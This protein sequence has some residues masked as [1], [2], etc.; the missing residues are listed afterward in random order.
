MARVESGDPEGAKADFWALLKAT[1][2]D[3]KEAV[4]QLMK[5]MPKEEVQ[6]QFKKLQRDAE[7]EEKLGS[8]LKELD[9]DERIA[10]QEERYMRF[11]GDCEQRAQ[12][13]QREISFDEWVKQYEWRYD[14]DERMK[15]RKDFPECFSHTGPAPLPVEEWEVDY[16]THKEIE[17]IVYRR[18]TEALG[19]KRRQREGEK[20]SEDAAGGKDGFVSRLQVDKEDE[21]ILKDA[22][23]KKGYN[24]W[25]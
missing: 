9:E 25:W 5:L 7:K 18:Q 24:Y 3:S 15:A 16:L 23:V 19:A 1:G 17:K 13:G 21:K 10:L 11:L 4:S 20:A 2:F 14:A 8:M 22:V 6:K 12:D